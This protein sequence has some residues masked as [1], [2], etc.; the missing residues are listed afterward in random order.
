MS[1]NTYTLQSKKLISC[2]SPL[3][4]LVS[5]SDFIRFSLCFHALFFC[6]LL[7][8]AWFS[9]VLGSWLK[10]ANMTQIS[11]F[12]S[13]FWIHNMES[14]AKAK[15]WW[16]CLINDVSLSSLET[17]WEWLS[18]LMRDWYLADEGLISGCL[19]L[20]HFHQS[21]WLLDTQGCHQGFRQP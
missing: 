21:I 5:C 13:C 7:L 8:S 20:L 14:R 11:K 3:L 6:W 2:T 15:I 1:G 16:L 19:I 12:D 17:A 4:V 10:L 9:L 18:G